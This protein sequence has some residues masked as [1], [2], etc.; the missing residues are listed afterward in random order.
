MGTEATIRL[1]AEEESNG[2]FWDMF[3]TVDSPEI[4]FED[5]NMIS[6]FVNNNGN[7]G[8]WNLNTIFNDTGSEQLLLESV[9]EVISD[10]EST[11]DMT[12]YNEQGEADGTVTYSK[13][14]P[15]HEMVIN[16]S[17]V[18][19]WNTEDEIGYISDDGEKM[20]WEGRGTTASDVECSEV[21][22]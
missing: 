10:D 19:Y 9:W 13:N 8:F 5:Y 4:S 22:L 15:V 14:V 17:T 3:L 6:G 16:S 11:L 12:I 21:G 7:E 18:I 20:C 2:I 1:T